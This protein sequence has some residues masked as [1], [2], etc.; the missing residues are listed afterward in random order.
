RECEFLADGRVLLDAKL[1]SRQTVADHFV[2]EG[3][4][5]LH[6]CRL[7]PRIDDPPADDRATVELEELHQRTRGMANQI[8]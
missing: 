2:E 8:M 5:G 1:V 6:F 7:E 3:T 4:Q